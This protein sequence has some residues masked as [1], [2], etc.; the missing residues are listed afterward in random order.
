MNTKQEV[1]KNLPAVDKLLLNP[2]VKLLLSAHGKGAVIF[3]I[4]Q[5]LNYFRIQIQNGQ[6]LPTQIEILE[7]IKELLRLISKRSLKKLTNATGIVMHTNLGRSPFGDVFLKESFDILKGYNNLEFDLNTASRGSRHV[8]AAEILKFLT[9][10]EDVLVVNNAAAAVMLILRTFA[11]RKEVVISR[12]ELIE[13]GGSFRIPDIMK[14][15]DCKMVEVGTTNKTKKEDFTNAITPKTALI[16]KA[17]KSNYVIKGFTEEVDMCELIALGKKHQIPFVYD[18]GSGL[19]KTSLHPLF[20]NEP[21]ATDAI[22]KGVDL[23]CFSGDKILGGPQAGII[24]GR[25]DLIARLKKEPMLRALRVCKTTLVMLETVCKYHIDEKVLREKNIIYKILYRKHTDIN[26]TAEKLAKM[27]INSSIDVEVIA[28]K[29]FCGGGTMPEGEI[30]S[31][32]VKFTPKGNRKENVIMAEKL[33]YNL[34]QHPKPILGILKK[35]ELYL[36]ILCIF[37]EQLEEMAMTV[38]ET[39]KLLFNKK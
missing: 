22:N 2:E 25:K 15:S 38:K 12:G 9:G 24:A 10:A 28:S 1:L 32:A 26:N 20:K 13:I 21:S 5:C 31:Y 23:V 29:G 6:S 11:K 3:C 19:L 33:Y 14:A 39:Y 18:L 4:R 7:K 36:D 35:G 27:L 37:D 16:F 30:E 8:H 17:H 34:L